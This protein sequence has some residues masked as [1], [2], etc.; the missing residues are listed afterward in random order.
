MLKKII[1]SI[2][3][4]SS[5]CYSCTKEEKNKKTFE[6]GN[7]VDVSSKIIFVKNDIILGKSRLSIIGKYLLAKDLKALDKGLVLF[8]KNTFEYVT[9][10]GTRG[11]GPGEI[12]NYGQLLTVSDSKNGLIYGFDYGKLSL[13]CF[14]L[15]SVLLSK[16]Y[17]P[18]EVLRL[19]GVKMP[20]RMVQYN[21]SVFM[22]R[23]L[24][25]IEK[26]TFGERT[27]T[28]NCK[29]GLIKPFGYENPELKTNRD[30]RGYFALS[31]NNGVYVNCYSNQDLMTICKLDGSL[32]FN[33]LG[34]E[35]AN[36]NKY[37]KLFYTGVQIFN[38][39]IIASYVGSEATIID[40]YKRR[41]GALPTQ[42][43][44]FDISG[45]YLKTLET[46][47]EIADFCIDSDSGRLIMFLADTDQ[48]LSYIDL[49]S[50][51]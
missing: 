40:K 13:L 12:S 15:D 32:L 36:N 14:S 48:S 46:K 18:Q 2:I 23:G 38:D 49:K 3:V 20:G 51:L 29:T 10:T 44:V 50:L 28:F 1:C 19:D 41:K 24:Q 4:L 33:V 21:D 6:N 17:L 16:K 34:S 37:R 45:N 30:T 39:K 25:I 43:L 47:H 5:L 26:R 35:W 9:S 42:F 11:Q 31:H 27:I 8:D 22:G 7:I